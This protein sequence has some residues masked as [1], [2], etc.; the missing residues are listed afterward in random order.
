MTAG[1]PCLLGDPLAEASGLRDERL[2][3]AFAPSV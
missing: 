1:N 3:A 2:D